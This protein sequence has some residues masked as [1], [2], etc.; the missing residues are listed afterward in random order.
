VRGQIILLIT[1]KKFINSLSMPMQYMNALKEYYISTRPFSNG[2]HIIHRHD[3]PFL[4]EPG[5]RTFLGA[6]QSPGDA[7]K[8]GIMHF[9]EPA[10]CRFCSK[11][12]I[13]R[14]VNPEPELKPEPVFISFDRLKPTIESLM[15][16][17]VS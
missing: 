3:C 8:E 10:C 12:G 7:L 5:N 2:S 13:D 11:E 4:P 17:S 9:R 6:F 16:C 14:K 15:L 1:E